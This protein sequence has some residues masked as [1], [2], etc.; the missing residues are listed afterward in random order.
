MKILGENEIGIRHN[1]VS[2]K[3]FDIYHVNNRNRGIG[4]AHSSIVDSI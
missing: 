2:I 4:I 1:E 3:Y